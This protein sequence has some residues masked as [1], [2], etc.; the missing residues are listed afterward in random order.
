MIITVLGATG[1]SG[2]HFIRKACADGHSVRALVR[3]PDNFIKD[4]VD[5]NALENLTVISD[6]DI[7]SADNLAEGFKGSDAVV[8]CLGS[9]PSLM[10]WGAEITLYSESIK[11]IVGAM[12]LVR[13]DRLVAMTSQFTDDDP[14]CGFFVRWILKPLFMGRNMDDMRRMEK[15]LEEECQGC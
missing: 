15:Y 13:L 6:V 3:N 1:W 4:L 11:S 10:P 9:K 7:F 8:S 2:Q 12:R 14:N 5:V